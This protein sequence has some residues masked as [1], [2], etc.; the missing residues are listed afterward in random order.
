MSDIA[1]SAGILEG[2]GSFLV[3]GHKIRVDCQMTDKDIVYRLQ[4]V[5]GT[6]TVVETKTSQ[7]HHKR[8]WKWSVCGE[9]ARAVMTA[10]RP[11]MGERR[12]ARIDEALAAR[13]SLDEKLA[14]RARVHASVIELH[15]T[16]ISIRETARQLG[17]RFETVR[18]IV[19]K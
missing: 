5:F 1:W 16:G 8:T 19:N 14:E 11:W 13:L 12:G 9:N 10:I 7:A 2:E 3:L 6:G 17:M 4:A 15:G 18:N